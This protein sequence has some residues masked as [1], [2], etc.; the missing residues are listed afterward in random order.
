VADV[1]RLKP[2]IRAIKKRWL[3]LLGAATALVTL[4]QFRDAIAPMWMWLNADATL[5][6]KIRGLATGQA[7]MHVDALLGTPAIVR[8]LPKPNSQYLERIYID[9]TCYIRVVTD[10]IG[11]VLV[12]AVTTARSGCEIPLPDEFILKA[13]LE[14]HPSIGRLHFSDVSALSFESYVLEG[15]VPYMIYQEQYYLIRSRDQYFLGVTGDALGD[16]PESMTAFMDASTDA[17]DGEVPLAMGYRDD[18][19]VNFAGG[20]VPHRT[21]GAIVPRSVQRL[22][23]ILRPNTF[24][25]AALDAPQALVK[26]VYEDFRGLGGDYI[27]VL[28]TYFRKGG[29]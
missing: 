8:R 9:K 2:H 11:K 18:T 24:A 4:A 23:A 5:R 3:V 21:E 27:E 14:D 10:D 20:S 25:V 13:E 19:S 28:S 7:A 1:M 22:R 16:D 15:A 29:N 6:E 12:L 26:A 17:L